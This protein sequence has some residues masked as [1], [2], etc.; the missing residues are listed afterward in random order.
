MYLTGIFYEYEY[1]KQIKLKSSLPPN[2]CG[3]R[4]AHLFIFCIVLVCIFMFWVWCCDV[5]YDF[6]I[7]MMFGSSLPPVDFMRARVISTLF[8]FACI[9]W[10]STQCVVFLLCFSSSCVPFVASFSGLSN[11]IAFSVFSNVYL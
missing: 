6:C 5:H 2:F 3:V 11:L 10:C 9:L 7:K 1:L 4:V 8:V